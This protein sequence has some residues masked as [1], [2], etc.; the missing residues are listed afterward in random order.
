MPNPKVY[1]NV[2]MS[3]DQRKR[4][5]REEHFWTAPRLVALAATTLGTALV[6]LYLM[7]SVTTET[8]WDGWLDPAGINHELEWENQE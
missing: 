7:S 1:I 8:Y 4:L 6:V 5:E 2:Q 3:D